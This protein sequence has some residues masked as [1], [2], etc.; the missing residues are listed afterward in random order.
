MSEPE[1]RLCAGCGAE[2]P[3]A[4]L[5]AMPNATLCVRCQAGAEMPEAVE[6][7]GKCPKCGSPLV[8]KQQ[9]DPEK[10]TPFLAC[11]AF[12]DCRYIDPETGYGFERR[13]RR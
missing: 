8:W 3:S 1:R 11:S 10:T 13:S 5:K 12:P 9:R 7:A 4:R 6:S 2:I